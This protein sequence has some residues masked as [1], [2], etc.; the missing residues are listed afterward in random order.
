MVALPGQEK[1]RSTHLR[2]LIKSQGWHRL[3]QI[4]VASQQAGAESPAKACCKRC[5]SP[6]LWSNC[7]FST[8]G[9]LSSSGTTTKLLLGLMLPEDLAV[10]CSTD[11]MLL[12]LPA[13]SQAMPFMLHGKGQDVDNKESGE[14][15]CMLP[16]QRS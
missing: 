9:S 11:S 14:S 13:C 6:A 4:D 15:N 12:P 16:N 2:Q 8:G 1:L 7:I 3:D 5:C 10:A